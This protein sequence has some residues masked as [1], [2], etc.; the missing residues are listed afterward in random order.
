MAAAFFNA[1]AHPAHARAISAGTQPAA[2]VHANVIAVMF[3]RSLDLSA[4]RP[5]TLTPDL[6]DGVQWVITMGCDD[7]PSVQGV[8]R[9]EWRVAD[10]VDQPLDAVRVIADQIERHV[11]KLIVREG[12]VRLQP[13]GTMRALHAR[14]PER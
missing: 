12:W 6:L 14:K 9:D 10:P 5:Q 8:R 11:W 13:R 4:A 1:M 3:E 7:D 2:Q